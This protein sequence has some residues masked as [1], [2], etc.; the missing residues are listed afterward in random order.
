MIDQV[1]GF[2]LGDKLAMRIGIAVGINIDNGIDDR[3]GDLGAGGA[4]EVNDLM[5]VDYTI[6]RRE[7]AANSGIHWKGGWFRM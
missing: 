4:V 6:K 1:V 3:L 7:L 2:V 5:A